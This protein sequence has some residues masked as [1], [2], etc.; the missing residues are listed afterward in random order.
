MTN[1]I[2]TPENPERKDQ[3]PAVAN[4]F[5]A[6]MERLA[7]NKDVDPDKLGKLLDLQE[8]ILDRN[9]KAAFATAMNACQME[10]QPIK[11]NARNQQTSSNYANL[12]A[13]N[14]AAI[15]IYTKHGFSLSFG[16]GETTQ[17]ECIRITCDV[18]HVGGHTKPYFYDCPIDIAGLQ[19]KANKTRTHA[20]GSSTSYG[21]RYLTAMIFNLTLTDED[22]D[23]NSAG[24]G[25]TISQDQIQN[26]YDLM[27]E[28]G[29]DESRFLASIG[30]EALEDMPQANYKMAENL[31]L[32]KRALRRGKE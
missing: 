20:F 3:L 6:M 7:T 28:T 25:G 22:D 21:K 8:R 5:V 18:S 23:G 24:D 15:P 12:E 32:S 9:A 31:L 13:V 19:G 29:T 11:R 10:M 14:R 27:Q 2:D 26:L 16:N 17:P 30:L 1:E 4:E